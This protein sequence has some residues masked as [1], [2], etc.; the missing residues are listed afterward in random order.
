[1]GGLMPPSSSRALRWTRVVGN[2]ATPQ[3]GKTL[4][5]EQEF[6]SE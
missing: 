6:L 1:M 5:V 3:K 2:L 4:S